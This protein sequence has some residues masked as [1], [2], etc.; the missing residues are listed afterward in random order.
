MS[1]KEE[2]QALFERFSSAWNSG[3]AKGASGKYAED[4]CLISPFG[5]SLLGPPAMSKPRASRSGDS[6][7]KS[8]RGR[9]SRVADVVALR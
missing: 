4:G 3:D 1:V 6:S 8:Q 2:I 5:D 7:S 9:L